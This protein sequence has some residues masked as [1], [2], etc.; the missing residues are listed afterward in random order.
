MPL[1][2]TLLCAVLALAAAGQA[3]AQ[4]W[5]ARPVRLI[6][7]QAPGTSPDITARLIGERLARLWG[8]SVVV[9]NRAGGQN[10]IGAQAAARSAPD[11][12]TF[13]YATTAAIV[14]NPVTFKSL[15]YDPP[16]DFAAVAMVAKSPMVVAVGASVP[17]K[18]L[19][20]LIALDRAKPGSL[21]AAHE[22][23]RTF[24]GMMSAA[25]NLATGMQALQVPYNG[26][27]PAIQDTVGGRTQI[28]LLSSAAVAPFIKRGDLRPLAVTVGRRVTGL[29][30][31]PT[32]A[33]TYPGFDYSGW[34]ALLAPAGTPTEVIARVNRDVNQVLADAEVA[35]RLASM[36]LVLE[37]GPPEAL[38]EFLS[39]ERTRWA[40]L[41]K[42][43]GLIPE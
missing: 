4:A 33:E 31:V 38:N 5:P 29:E 9:E 39:A 13:F 8:Q 24:S 30:N 35:Q 17:A 19:A 26:A 28:V 25:L 32:L 15:P 41:V 12:Y 40:R 16:R 21:S 11:G 2:R 36:G 3:L 7:S 18:S 37:P 42:D 14:T 23:P 22:G 20:E 1:L 34:F 43:I 6:V 27:T 10:V